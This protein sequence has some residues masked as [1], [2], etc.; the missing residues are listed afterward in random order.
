[1]E[2]TPCYLNNQEDIKKIVEENHNLIYSFLNIRNLN[3]EEYYDIAALGLMKAAKTFDPNRKVKF[4]TYAYTVMY[5]FIQH[6]WRKKIS[7][8][9][10]NDKEL[11]YYNHIYNLDNS[12]SLLDM[13]EDKQ[14]N[15]EDEVI[16]KMQVVDFCKKIKNKTHKDVFILFLLGY[17][18][19]SIAKEMQV[20]IN[21]IN[22]VINRFSKIFKK[23]VLNVVDKKE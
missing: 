9:R 23:E 19:K 18:R 15:I 20:S 6:E 11:L 21:L 13:I 14:I 22:N 8:S 7:L 3:I 5:N 1:M 2:T 10:K 17:D 12:V 16:L 4:S